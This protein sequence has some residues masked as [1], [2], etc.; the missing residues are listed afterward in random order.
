MTKHLIVSTAS[1]KVPLSG[2]LIHIRSGPPYLWTY[3]NC[4]PVCSVQMEHKVKFSIERSKQNVFY[5]IDDQNLYIIF[6]K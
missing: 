6:F 2:I 5:S 1:N 4:C 3:P